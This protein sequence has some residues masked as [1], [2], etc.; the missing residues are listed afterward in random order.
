MNK[1]IAYCGLA[2]CVCSENESCIG[3]RNDGCKDKEWCKNYKCCRE[4][5]LNGCWECIDFPCSGGMLDK[6]RIRAFARFVKEYGEDELIRCLIRNK[7]TGVVFHYDGQLIG[8]YDKGQTEEE[9]IEIIKRGINKVISHYDSLIDEN[10]DPTLDPKPLQEYM[11]KWDGQVFIDELQLSPSKDVLEIGVGT[12]RL[13]LKV[14][15]KCKSFTGI[16]ISPKT[17]ERAKVNLSAYS[18]VNLICNNFMGYSFDKQFDIVYSSLTF[19][20]I[21]EKLTAINKI[22]G[23]LKSNGRFILS[24]DKNQSEYIEFGDRKVK[25]YPDNPDSIYEHIIA[26]KL[27]LE[28]QFETEFAIVFVARKV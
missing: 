22:A 18:N 27:M 19:M 28:K 20:H 21:E 12:G 6:L 7:E 24:V 14:C 2:C 9:I 13:A 17:I 1:Q 16:D 26:A 25:I 10:N 5:D 8:D 15:G 4:K 23:L 3:C 11:D